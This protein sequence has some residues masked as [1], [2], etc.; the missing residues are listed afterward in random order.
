VTYGRAAK[1][2]QNHLVPTRVLYLGSL[3]NERNGLSRAESLRE[4]AR[5]RQC[6][7]AT[8]GD[9][10]VQSTQPYVKEDIMSKKTSKKELN[11]PSGVKGARSSPAV[12]LMVMAPVVAGPP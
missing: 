12:K 3:P 7:V 10:T 1:N 11:V 8:W 9:R 4:R 6:Q 2:R 5:I